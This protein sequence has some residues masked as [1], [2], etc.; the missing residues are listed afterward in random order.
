MQVESA[1]GADSQVV[2]SSQDRV[3]TPALCLLCRLK[4]VRTQGSE[5][6]V[7]PGAV[8]EGVDVSTILLAGI[9]DVAE[10]QNLLAGPPA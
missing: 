9:I 8:V 6:T 2:W 10:A 5:M 3:D 1:V 4:R 7:A